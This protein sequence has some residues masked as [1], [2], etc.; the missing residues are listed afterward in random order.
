MGHVEDRWFK[1]VPGPDGKP[2]RVRTVRYGQGLRYRV[3]YI[4]PD[5]RERS[6]SFPDRAK[7]D[8]EGF[9]AAIETDKRRGSYVDPNAGRMPFDEFAETWLRT[10]RFD[11]SARGPIKARVRKHVISYF[12]KRP[13][14]TVQP[15]T[16]RDWDVVLIGKGL[17]DSTRAVLFA[18]LSGIM[19]AAVDDGLIV[20]NPCSAKS[21]TAPVPALKRIVP[22]TI[23]AVAAVREGL[24]PRY[25]TAVDI[26]AG[27]G[28]RRGEI[29]GVSP[30]DFDFDD[31]WLTICRQVKR[32]G[33]RS[34]FGLP[35]N[36]QERRVPLPDSVSRAV[37]VHIDEFP[38]VPVTLPWEDPRRDERVT[39]PLLLT[40]TFRTACKQQV[41]AAVAWHRAL[42]G[43]GLER[44]RVNGMHALRHFYASAL[45]DAGETIK[46]IAEWLG[47]ADPAF[48][49]RVYAH[50]MPD[51]PG[52]ARKALDAL[53]DGPSGFHGPAT[54]QSGA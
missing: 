31:G 25:R 44:T 49:L 21:V 43:A 23:D 18:H 52:R 32:V 34:V 4:A 17:A 53:F 51:S 29:F 20:K 36:D 9:L 41:F 8:A 26:G 13:I 39:V 5:G 6:K 42:D 54:A 24:P 11:E 30:E 19:T 1:E 35:K 22:W 33:A 15:S 27:C 37:R 45:L 12:G 46:A 50:L 28:A 2:Q 10:R 38:P 7:R 40:T 47:H 14:G 48:T 16:V 3:R